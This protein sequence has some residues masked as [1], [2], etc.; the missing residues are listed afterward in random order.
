[1]ET[2]LGQDLPVGVG[3]KSGNFELK[4]ATL[5]T[6]R[7]RRPYLLCSDYTLTHFHP[8][9][10]RPRPSVVITK[11]STQEGQKPANVTSGM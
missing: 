5:S 10:P 7:Q 4:T 3:V 2:E 1:M 6:K 11:S 9:E 8:V